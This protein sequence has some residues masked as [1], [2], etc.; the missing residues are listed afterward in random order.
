ML[1][2][3]RQYVMSTARE[4]FWGYILLP[5]NGQYNERIFASFK[6]YSELLI[7]QII[8]VE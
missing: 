7:I 5:E 2:E 4:V 8:L 1:R 6:L 3:D